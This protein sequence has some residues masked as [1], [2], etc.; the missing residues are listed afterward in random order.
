MRKGGFGEKWRK[1]L[2]KKRGEKLNTPED[3]AEAREA[4][5]IYWWRAGS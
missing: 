3:R 2:A 4:L 5:K 1:S